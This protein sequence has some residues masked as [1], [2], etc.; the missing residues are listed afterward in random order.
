MRIKQYLRLTFF[1]TLALASCEK[2]IDPEINVDPDAPLEVTPDVMLPG[3]QASLAYYIGGFDIGAT[4][5]IWMQQIQGQA[6]QALAI[7]YYVFRAT[8]PNN[9]WNSMYSGVMMDLTQMI[10]VCDDPETKSPALGGIS[11]VLLAVA[12]GQITDLWGDI[13]YSEAFLGSADD[14]VFKP[15]LDSQQEI[16]A[17]IRNLIGEAI[18]D[19]QDT[20]DPL[21]QVNADYYYNGDINAWLRAAYHMRARYEM[22]LQKVN[23]PFD[24]AAVISDLDRGFTS[25][26]DDMEQVFNVSITGQNPLYQF[27]EQREGY[28]VDNPFFESL[29]KQ[30]ING[31][32]DPRDGYYSWSELGYWTRRYAPVAIA[33][34]TE[35]LFLRA[36]A[37][38]M[39]GDEPQARAVLKYAIETSLTKYQVNMDDSKNAQWLIDI[40]ADIDTRTGTDLLE[41]IMVEKYKHMFC[42]L[43]SWTDWR[44]TGFP[45]LTP[46][47]GTR[48]PRR[49]PYSQHERDYNGDNTPVVQIYSRVWWDVE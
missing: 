32:R 7:N 36:E 15:K 13:P 21:Y 43:E 47:Q 20:S 3:V 35:A 23:L 8:D 6:Q 26:S 9:L 34:F 31:T 14:P 46:K 22:H 37:L 5:G 42:Q 48:I 38:Y 33:Q 39:S 1:L 25:L 28:V 27:I 17:E 45:Q 44:R 30:R 2:W 29:F 16:Y 24:Y 10:E 12:L 18:T 40:G 11:K 19:L 4:P 41:F 49:Y